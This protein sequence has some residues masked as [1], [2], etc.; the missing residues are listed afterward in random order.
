MISRA[1]FLFISRNFEAILWL[2]VLL[3]LLLSPIPTG[4]HLIICPFRLVGF[5]HCPGCGLGTALCLLLHGYISESVEMHPLALLALPILVIR[6]Y[7]IFRDNYKVQK[8]FNS[9]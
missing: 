8:S 2:A 9:Y 7:T 4:D 6:T 3:V 1:A 5:Q